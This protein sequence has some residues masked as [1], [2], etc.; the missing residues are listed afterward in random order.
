MCVC[1]GGGV[2]WQKKTERDH[3]LRE[4]GGKKEKPSVSLTAVDFQ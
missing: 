1:V 4:R 3:A 2:W